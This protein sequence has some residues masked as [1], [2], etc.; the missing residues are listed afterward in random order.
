MNAPDAGQQTAL[1]KA[2]LLASLQHVKELLDGGANPN[3]LDF[4][5]DSPIHLAAMSMSYNI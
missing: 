3:A 1:H 4:A 5:G 2:V